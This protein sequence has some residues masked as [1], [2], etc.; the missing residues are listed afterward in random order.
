MKAI[1]L[2]I[3]HKIT[4]QKETNHTIKMAQIIY[5]NATSAQKRLIINTR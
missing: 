5:T 3:I 4:D 2:E 1:G